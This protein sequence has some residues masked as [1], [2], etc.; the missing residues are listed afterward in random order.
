MVESAPVKKNRLDRLVQC[1]IAL[2]KQRFIATETPARDNEWLCGRKAGGTGK[3]PSVDVGV[4]LSGYVNWWAGPTACGT[5][6]CWTDMYRTDMTANG[7][8]DQGV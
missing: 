6:I 4:C 8:F 1:T 2:Y 3:V 5:D 7:A